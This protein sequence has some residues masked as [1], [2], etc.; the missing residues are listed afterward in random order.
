MNQFVLCLSRV[1]PKNTTIESILNDV[2]ELFAQIDVD[3]SSR[4]NWGEFSAFCIEVGM[5]AST[6]GK[7]KRL[8]NTYFE[9]RYNYSD[10]TL[11]ADGIRRVRYFQR[12]DKLFVLDRGEPKIWVYKV[13]PPTDLTRVKPRMSSLEAERDVTKL[14][15]TRH[16]SGEMYLL[17]TLVSKPPSKDHLT[18]TEPGVMDVCCLNEIDVLA[19]ATSGLSLAFWSIRCYRE[20]PPRMEPRFLKSVYTR[21]P[22]TVLAWDGPS[23]TL[24]SSGGSDMVVTRWKIQTTPSFACASMCRY[25]GHVGLVSDMVA[26]PEFDMLATASLDGQIFLWS[27]TKNKWLESRPPLPPG[28][29]PY[30][31]GKPGKSRKVKSRIAGHGDTGVRSITYAGEGTLLSVAFDFQIIGWNIDG[32][33]SRPLFKLTGD[34]VPLLG[35]DCVPGTGTAVT[36][37]IEGTCRRW[38]ISTSEDGSVGDKDRC[39]QIW[40]LKP[41]NAEDEIGGGGADIAIQP[42]CMVMTKPSGSIVMGGKSLNVF[43]QRVNVT[44]DAPVACLA[45]NSVSKT[46]I[47]SVKNNVRIWCA[48]TGQ[49]LR[50]HIGVMHYDITDISL[51]G[52]ERKF[53]LGDARGNVKAFNYLNGMPMDG[54]VFKKH[55]RQ[56]SAI[57]YVHAEDRTMVTSSWDGAIRVFLDEPPR[58]GESVLSETR[59]LLRS[60]E[61]AHNSDITALA[62]SR[63]LSMI[64][65]GESQGKIKIWDLEFCAMEGL[66]LGHSTEVTALLFLDP[67]P[68][69][70]S[71][72]ADGN[73]CLW[74]LFPHYPRCTCIMRWALPRLGDPESPVGQSVTKLARCRRGGGMERERKEGEEKD[75]QGEEKGDQ[76][77]EKDESKDDDGEG[78]GEDLERKDDDAHT[79][80]AS[81]GAD[82]SPSSSSE[83]VCASDDRGYVTCWDLG[84]V[85][86]QNK[87]NVPSLKLRPTKKNSFNPRRRCERETDEDTEMKHKIKDVFA[88]FDEDESGEI[89]RYELRAALDAMGHRMDQ[90]GVDALLATIDFDGN[91]TVEPDEFEHLVMHTLVEKSKKEE[92]N[93]MRTGKRTIP[94]QNEPSPDDDNTG[95][96]ATEPFRPFLR[97]EAHKAAVSNLISISDPSAFLTSG[98][99]LTVRLWDSEGKKLGV[100]T[101]GMLKDAAIR[102]LK[103]K[104]KWCFESDMEALQEKIERRSEDIMQG[105]ARLEVEEKTTKEAMKAAELYHAHLQE[106]KEKSALA[107]PKSPGTPGVFAGFGLPLSPTKKTKVKSRLVGQLNGEVTWKLNAAEEGYLGRLQMERDDIEKGKKKLRKEIKEAYSDP[108]QQ[109]LVRMMSDDHI[110]PRI[111]GY[112]GAIETLKNEGKTL[113]NIL[114]PLTD[115]NLTHTIDHNEMKER[116][117]QRKKARDDL[118]LPEISAIKPIALPPQDVNNWGFNSINRQRQLYPAF[119]EQ[120]DRSEA[121]EKKKEESKK[122]DPREVTKPSDFLQDELQKET[123][124]RK[125]LSDA[126]IAKQRG[127]KGGGRAKGRAK[128]TG[129]AKPTPLIFTPADPGQKTNQKERESTSVNLSQRLDRKRPP[130][131]TVDGAAPVL[132]VGDA[133]PVLAVGDAAGPPP[134][135]SGKAKKKRRRRKKRGKRHTVTNDAASMRKSI[136]RFLNQN[137]H[138]RSMP[139][140]SGLELKVKRERMIDGL[141]SA[142]K[143]TKRLQHEVDTV[144][145]T[146]QYNETAGPRRAHLLDRKRS[147]KSLAKLKYNMFGETT[148]GLQLS[149]GE[150]SDASSFE[151]AVVEEKAEIEFTDE[152]I[153]R[154]RSKKNFG[155]YQVD[156][157]KTFRTIIRDVDEDHSGEI[158]QLEFL[159]AIQKL[160]E[161]DIKL[162]TVSGTGSNR[163]G[164]NFAALVEKAEENSATLQR[165]VESMFSSI[166]SDGSGS[167]TVDEIVGVLFPRA[168]PDELKDIHMYLMMPDT[169]RFVENEEEEDQE[170]PLAPEHIEE[171]KM[172]FDIYDEDG[173]GTLDLDELRNAVSG[174]FLFDDAAADHDISAN[175]AG[176]TSTDFQR[177]IASADMDGDGQVDF[178]E[179]VD[180]MRHIYES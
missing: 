41:K 178:E 161:K 72:D 176:V 26:L 14:K 128:A 89:D 13:N 140:I 12:T 25:H 159:M 127:T 134:Q 177:F 138:H 101:R 170:V 18:E 84:K 143:I 154:L 141:S 158:D 74:T 98:D 53:I 66:C 33:T 126:R 108:D 9:Q 19:L 115:G 99:D 61:H 123:E 125:A 129:A 102:K 78:K 15:S 151:E 95:A 156:M 70:V 164:E 7:N 28:R 171:L 34:R 118:S 137:R 167:I 163:T 8:P 121:A 47:G 46:I 146:K 105:V 56:I 114:V 149:S 67:K 3:G 117:V 39:L 109:H 37:N 77:E 21:T 135:G 179:W 107:S 169:P 100:L 81:D 54:M 55:P 69:L 119:Y 124:R 90:K 91:G 106:I 96:T 174:S 31:K 38:D 76:S 4:I 116:L 44:A 175:A 136:D 68:L 86:E 17:H 110:A 2:Q 27:T 150:E 52:R 103:M 60:I 42:T 23:R 50:Q 75:D 104:E 155:I 11:H 130:V 36:M 58:E 45:Y 71:A 63:E 82:A 165:M 122:F 10:I 1:L 30:I 87:V 166:D 144:F 59:T 93:L 160:H 133:A 112:L 147:T 173:S 79:L 168:P 94:N 92:E 16:V 145:E 22:Q 64:A 139:D 62:V 73:M 152:I 48:R 142:E 24:F 180:M 49:M 57:R 65:S 83:C 148:E 43:D 113:K 32:I 172:L 120:R 40:S 97:W 153:A 157:I 6:F 131:L 80:E 162:P 29:T 5:A 35:V 132:T 111:A 88:Y 20:M 51:D 85:I